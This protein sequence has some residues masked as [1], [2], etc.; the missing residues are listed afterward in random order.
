MPDHAFLV[1]HVGDLLLEDFVAVAEYARLSCAS[2][3]LILWI[4][5][6]HD[7]LDSPEFR[8][9][10]LGTG[11]GKAELGRGS[12]TLTITTLE[13]VGALFKVGVQYTL[14]IVS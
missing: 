14:S 12:P 4:E 7:V 3:G 8:E 9:R 2:R 10:N 6:E 5:V 1:N 13:V 11:A